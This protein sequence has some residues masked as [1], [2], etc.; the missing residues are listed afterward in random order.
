MEMIIELL[1]M[2]WK[3]TLHVL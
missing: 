3:W 2:F 1:F